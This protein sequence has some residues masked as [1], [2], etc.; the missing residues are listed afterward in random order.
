MFLGPRFVLELVRILDGS[1]DGDV[2][3]DNPTYVSPRFLRRTA[4][5]AAVTKTRA[6]V[7]EKRNRIVKENMLKKII[8]PDPVGE[9]FNEQVK[10]K[11]A[12]MLMDQID[13]KKNK[14][15]KGRIQKKAIKNK[16]IKA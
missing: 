11:K 8:R 3:F 10:S 12:K 13:S 2:L 15:R 9:I 6:R 4:R 5:L 7:E 1:F 16:S 14:S